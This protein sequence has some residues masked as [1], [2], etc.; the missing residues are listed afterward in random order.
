MLANFLTD[1]DANGE[2]GTVIS[3]VRARGRAELEGHD[4]GAREIRAK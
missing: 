3:V 1:D 4:R 2:S